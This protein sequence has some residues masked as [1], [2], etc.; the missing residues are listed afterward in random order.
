MV[1]SI[2][3]IILAAI[4]NAFMDK[5][6]TE[7]QFKTSRF[8]K[9]N[10]EFWCKPISAD[11]LAFIDGTKYRADAWHIAKSIMIVFLINAIVFYTPLAGPFL[12]PFIKFHFLA[13]AAIEV[14]FLG[15]IW[16]VV[17]D[18]FYHKIFYSK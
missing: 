13:G 5:V 8:K 12:Q 1:L 3:F 9:L 16:N 10:K 14:L 15:I 11:S 6:E 2:I 17:F 4:C 18:L 7:I